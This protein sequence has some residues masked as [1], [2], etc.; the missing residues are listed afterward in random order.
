LKGGRERNEDIELV[1]EVM[2]E[3]VARQGKGTEEVVR[4]GKV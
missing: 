1:G 3:A 2:R 4:T